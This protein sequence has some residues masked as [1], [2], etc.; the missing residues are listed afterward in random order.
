MI[1]GAMALT[2]RRS[3]SAKWTDDELVLRIAGGDP[4]SLGQLYDR[5]CAR[6]YGQALAMLGTADRA[7][8]VTLQVFLA[9]WRHAGCVGDGS[10]RLWLAAAV[11]RRARDH[12]S[13]APLGGP[14]PRP[15]SP[16]VPWALPERSAD[17]GR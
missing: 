10:L 15:A 17:R 14:A 5:H 6:V 8:A 11:E 2:R 7:E 13:L 9:L 1:K 12:A 4:R 3:G 16:S